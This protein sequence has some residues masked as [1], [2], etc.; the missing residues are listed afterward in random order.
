VSLWRKRQVEE[1]N[2]ETKRI[3]NLSVPDTSMGAADLLPSQSERRPTSQT[4]HLHGSGD[5]SRCD[6]GRT[7]TLPTDKGA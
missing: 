6:T 4:Q 3:R 7:A 1:V 5:Q 2:G